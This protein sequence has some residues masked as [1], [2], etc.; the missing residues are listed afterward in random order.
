MLDSYQQ[1]SA[2]RYFSPLDT[3][4]YLYSAP[5]LRY[6]TSV[7]LATL[8]TDTD[9]APIVPRRRPTRRRTT[10]FLVILVTVVLVGNAVV[11]ER[12]LIA[13]IRAADQFEHL[14]QIIAVLQAENEG[15]REDGRRL[16]EEPRTIEE[17]ARSELGLIR[18]GETLFIVT[19]QRSDVVFTPA[20][21]ETNHP[22]AADPQP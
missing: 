22:A 19:D 17:L 10:R 12:G 6:S 9:P 4:F 3:T 8:P 21:V 16:R 2:T 7:A 20:A 18:P 15:L 1:R 5:E 14:S 13:M 11:G